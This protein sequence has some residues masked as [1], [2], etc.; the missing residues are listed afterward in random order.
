MEAAKTPRKFG[1]FGDTSFDVSFG[2]EA[3]EHD[4]KVNVNCC[5]SQIKNKW[6]VKGL[7]EE[8]VASIEELLLA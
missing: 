4:T 5:S 6:K 8:L 2:K 1:T 3:E 7:L